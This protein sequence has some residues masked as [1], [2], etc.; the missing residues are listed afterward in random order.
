MSR[1]TRG[2][3]KNG[4]GPGPLLAWVAGVEAVGAISAMVVRRGAWYTALAKPAWTPP[5]WVFA[6]VWVALYAT[7]AVAAWMVWRERDRLTVRKALIWFG[8]QLAFNALWNPLFF[9]FRR[10]DLAMLDLSL[11]WV[12]ILLTMRNFHRVRAVAGW[13]L[14]PYLAWVTFAG[15]LTLSIWVRNG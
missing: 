15:A 5:D 11:L 4:R 12:A 14:V 10:L 2:R 6:P 9:G 8:V 1:V 3:R 7:M 13:L